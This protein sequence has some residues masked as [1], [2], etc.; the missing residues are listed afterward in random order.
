MSSYKELTQY[1]YNGKWLSKREIFESITQGKKIGNHLYFG[2]CYSK[3][4]HAV[5]NDKVLIIYADCKGEYV[6]YKGE[7]VYLR[8][9]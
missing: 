9:E 1:Q 7:R 4:D 6:K 5:I 2:R 8:E 3:V